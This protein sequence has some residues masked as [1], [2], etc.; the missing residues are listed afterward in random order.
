[1][2][3]KVRFILL[4]ILLSICL[5]LMSNTYSRYVVDTTSNIDVLF[6]KWQILVSNV[7]ITDGSSSQ[8][9][10]TP[11][12]EENTNVATNVMAPSSTGYF[13]ILIDPTNVDVSFKYTI[14]LSIDAQNLPDLLITKY[15]VLPSNY[16]GEDPLNFLNITNNNIIDTKYIDNEIEN[17][18]FEPFTIRVYFEW[19]EGENEQMNDETDTGIGNTAVT[20]NTTF[21]INANIAFE[22]VLITT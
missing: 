9:S 7:D 14:S 2:L 16:N 21:T 20:E 11:I 12:I 22:Q 17:F 15:A 13:D 1:M 10:F 8:I 5:C 6:A 18:S 4:F 3:K 19:F